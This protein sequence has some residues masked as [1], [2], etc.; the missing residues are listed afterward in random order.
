[1]TTG[2]GNHTVEISWVQFLCDIEKVQC[3]NRLS[4][5]L[6][7]T[8]ILSHFLWITLSLYVEVVVVMCQLWVSTHFR[9]FNCKQLLAALEAIH[10]GS[11]WITCMILVLFIWVAVIKLKSKWTP[12]R[13]QNNSRTLIQMWNSL[14]RKKNLLN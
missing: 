2:L 14:L 13:M 10:I 4:D 6:A 1:M 12:L 8:I 3:H 9:C 7:G 11:V 5:P